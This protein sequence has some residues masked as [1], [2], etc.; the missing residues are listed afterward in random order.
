MARSF[1]IF[2]FSFIF[3]LLIPVL[4]VFAEDIP[5]NPYVWK[6]DKVYRFEYSKTVTVSPLNTNDGPDVRKTVISGVLIFVITEVTPAGAKAKMRM[7]SP[8]VTLPPIELYSS[9]ENDPVLQKDKDRVVAKAIEGTIKSAL[10]TVQL[11][12]DGTIVILDRTPADFKGWLQETGKVAGWRTKTLERL[13][14]M[15]ENDL[16]FRSP[17]E[18]RETL[19]ILGLKPQGGEGH[20]KM[21][22]Q[23]TDPS[24]I[25]QLEDK[26]Q[27]KF[28]RYI[29]TT[30][31]ATYS[32]PNLDADGEVTL[33]LDRVSSS[34]GTAVFD[35]RIGNLDTL[36][37]D[38][39]ADTTL[40][41]RKDTLER[42]INVQYRLR[43]LAPPI[44][45]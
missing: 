40:H 4:P 14:A 37:E 24:I 6:S 43:R 33:T 25:S 31:S 22:P 36:S 1:F 38:Y 41:Y 30:P 12:P 42:K 20:F 18:D 26:T 11:K 23:R 21:R 44:V 29:S 13:V 28:E 45:K 34:E 35:A 27:L 10:W 19:L 39:M 5:G 7:D 15:L 16:G 2:H 8:H 17:T 9:Q 32:I 3:S